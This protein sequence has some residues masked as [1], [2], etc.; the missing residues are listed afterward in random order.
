M[1]SDPEPYAA[2]LK[3]AVSTGLWAFQAV[4][5]ERENAFRDGFVGELR[6]RGGPNTLNGRAIDFDEEAR[7]GSDVVITWPRGNEGA[8]DECYLQIKILYPDYLDYLRVIGVV[9]P[10]ET[11]DVQLFPEWPKWR[12]ASPF[13]DA[14]YQSRRDGPY[15]GEYQAVRIAETVKARNQ[16]QKIPIAAGGFLLVTNDGKNAFVVRLGAFGKDGAP[17]KH[18]I[19]DLTGVK[20]NEIMKKGEGI[21]QILRWPQDEASIAKLLR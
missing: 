20:L 15:K 9:K 2:T 17:S 12:L 1:E 4:K 5:T 14:A 21:E 10:G 8:R 3:A 6:A 18:E 11:L 7:T 13:F 19:S 16:G